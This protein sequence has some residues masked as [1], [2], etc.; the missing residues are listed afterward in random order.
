MLYI[1]YLYKKNTFILGVPDTQLLSLGVFV[2]QKRNRNGIIS[3]QVK[4][5]SE[6]YTREE[7]NYLAALF[8][9]SIRVS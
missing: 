7:Q 8:E 1:I 5:F 3:V 9:L 2:R 6:I 4:V